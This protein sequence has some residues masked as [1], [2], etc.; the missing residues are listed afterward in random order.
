[1]GLASLPSAFDNYR[2]TT[3]RSKFSAPLCFAQFHCNSSF[4]TT[5]PHSLRVVVC[6]DQLDH[7]THLQHPARCPAQQ[8]SGVRCY[9]LCDST[10]ITI[11]TFYRPIAGSMTRTRCRSLRR[12]TLCFPSGRLKMTSPLLQHA[13]ARTFN[14]NCSSTVAAPC[15]RL[16]R[17]HVCASS[18]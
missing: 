17:P 18:S 3:S 13:L 7:N 1:M 4:I 8:Y 10:S 14:S 9:L 6:I 16:Q 5:V 12:P 11:R 2:V 15:L